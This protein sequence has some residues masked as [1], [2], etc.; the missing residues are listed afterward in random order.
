[1]NEWVPSG[2]LHPWDQDSPGQESQGSLY[3]Q[4]GT[5]G[6]TRVGAWGTAL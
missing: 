3:D 2:A 5:Q 6:L 1:M 4:V